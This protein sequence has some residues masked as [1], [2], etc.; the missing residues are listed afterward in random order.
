MVCAVDLTFS[1][2]YA[3]P[4]PLAHSPILR[5]AHSPIRGAAQPIRSLPPMYGRRTFGTVIVPSAF[6]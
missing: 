4:Y 1:P 3:G 2:S 5:F 6:W